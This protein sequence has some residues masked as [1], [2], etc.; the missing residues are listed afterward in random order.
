MDSSALVVDF[1]VWDVAYS[2][3]LENSDTGI[4][5]KWNEVDLSS[6]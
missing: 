2:E 6:S 5:G 3:F 4:A 1:Y